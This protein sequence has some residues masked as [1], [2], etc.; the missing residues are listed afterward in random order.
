MSACKA[1]MSWI[2]SRNASILVKKSL[3]LAVS[4]E[5][6]KVTILEP[7]R[8]TRKRKSKDMTCTVA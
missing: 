7:T 5:S 4:A 8:D 6:N 2:K 1:A 3:Q